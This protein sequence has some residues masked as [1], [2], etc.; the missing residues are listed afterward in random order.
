MKRTCWVHAAMYR[1]GWRHRHSLYVT[2]IAV[3][4]VFFCRVTHIYARIPRA[5]TD[6][7]TDIIARI[8]ADTSDTRDF[9]KLFLWQAENDTPAFS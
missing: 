2:R 6:T 1:T 3:L 8:L 5:D 7:D 9:L 4:I